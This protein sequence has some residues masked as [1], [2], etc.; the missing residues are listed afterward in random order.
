MSRALFGLIKGLLVGAAVGAAMIR[1]GVVA[2]PLIY[3]A[4]ALVG[5]LVG[6]VCGQAPWRS[7]TLWTPAVKAVIGAAVGGGLC[8]LGRYLLPE[9]RLASV[10]GFSVL[11][12]GAGVLAAAVGALYGTFVEVD[13]ST[14]GAA[15]DKKS[16]AKKP[17][18]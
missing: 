15:S 2:G 18:S 10:L 9:A 11:S 16:S 8:A 17:T 7:G 12:N 6:L 5:V 14:A 13:D 4:C 1:L 3:L